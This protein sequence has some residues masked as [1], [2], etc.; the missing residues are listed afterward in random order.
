MPRT[1][2]VHYPNA[3]NIQW[4][5][6]KTPEAGATATAAIAVT[7]NVRRRY[8]QRGPGNQ[9]W[10]AVWVASDHQLHWCSTIT[11]PA[12]TNWVFL[13]MSHIQASDERPSAITILVLLM[14]QHI[15]YPLLKFMWMYTAVEKRDT[16][17]CCGTGRNNVVSIGEL[18]FGAKCATSM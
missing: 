6:A 3:C 14:Q 18:S 8:T 17:F 15:R 13:P 16:G 1:I 10:L 7:A 12:A 5:R 2:L 9:R 11:V 4:C